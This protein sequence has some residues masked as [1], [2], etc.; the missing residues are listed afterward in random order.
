M[1]YTFKH[2]VARRAMV[3]ISK[4]FIKYDLL[5][6]DEFWKIMAIVN[7]SFDEEKK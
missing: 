4:H 6:K 1:K 2:E 5:N 7:K 3:L